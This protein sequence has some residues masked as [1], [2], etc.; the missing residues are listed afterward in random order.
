M[1]VGIKLYSTNQVTLQDIEFADFLEVLPVPGKPLGAFKDLKTKYRIHCAH[2]SHRFNPSDPKNNPRNEAII[3]EAIEAA[4]M[5]R[6]DRI[7]V[8]AGYTVKDMKITN[9]KIN[10]QK[11]LQ[12][13]PDKRIVIENLLPYDEGMVWVA[14]SPED[15]AEYKDLGFG[16]CLDFGHAI[17]TATYLK[18]DY[19]EY[20][21]DFARLKPDYMH[22]SGTKNGKDEHLSI[23]DS[24]QNMEFIKSTI[25][26][27]GKPVCLETP[28]DTERRKKEVKWLK[29]A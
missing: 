9:P 26:K 13:F 17:A 29:G 3:K 4:D 15:I 24:D 7:V 27:I 12:K 18:K 16:F 22:L 28:V 11:F 20:I 1:E 19:K 25:K 2:S 8:H 5:L 23:F 21:E 14:Y 10:S 6:A